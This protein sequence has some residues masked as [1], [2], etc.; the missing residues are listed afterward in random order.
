[1]IIGRTMLYFHSLV[2][3]LKVM[4]LKINFGKINIH[5]VA[6]ICLKNNNDDNQ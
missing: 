3:S 6:G 5:L 4:R 1:M 2:D